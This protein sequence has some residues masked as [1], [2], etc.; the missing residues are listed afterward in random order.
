MSALRPLDEQER[1]TPSAHDSK[2]AEDV[3]SKI[4]PAFRW[5]ISAKL[6]IQLLSWI[7]TL[8]VV[9]ILQPGDYG[10]N[11]MAMAVVGIAT[12]LAEFGVG[13]VTVQHPDLKRET[14]QTLF[15]FTLV[16]HS[17]LFV[18]VLGCTPL[19]I[20]FFSEPRLAWL[21]P[22]AALQF[23]ILAWYSIPNALLE[24]Q[25]RFR[26]KSIAD[27]V[28]TTFGII[29]TLTL[30][31]AGAG[32]WALIAGTLVTT[33]TRVVWINSIVDW[34]KRPA[35]VRSES[36]RTLRFA[37]A[38]MFSRVIWLA[39]AQSDVFI[40]GR[41]L[42]TQSVGLFT[43]ASE[44]ALAPLMK[45]SAP[46]S[47]V[48]VAAASRL[49]SDRAE[50]ARFTQ[51]TAHG[52]A[53]FA[54]PIFWGVS[55]VADVMIPLLFGAHWAAAAPIVSLIAIAGPIRAMNIAWMAA[56]TA[57]G[58]SKPQARIG[59]AAC[60]VFPSS[61]V[62]GAWLHGLVGAAAGFSLAVPLFFFHVAYEVRR[63]MGFPIAFQIKPMILPALAAALMAGAVVLT[64]RYLGSDGLARLLPEIGVGIA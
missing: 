14:L 18:A 47:S 52:V 38:L 9:R 33:L 27:I 12:L 26:E 51:N 23:P 24:R 7:A 40:I 6:C 42:G 62:A 5:V 31:L 8:V 17:V 58:Q 35:W 56:I 34:P 45:F 3:R 48:V 57:T 22:V 11:A 2:Q 46:I 19:M 10:I 1:V 63:A 53:L 36:E 60:A 49:Q 39:Q 16:L 43:V 13:T 50:L 20:S 4:A 54:F 28:A 37:G 61:L 32:Y 25:M 41:M 29:A 44:I 15:L 30:A 59:V 64:S 55:V 21:L